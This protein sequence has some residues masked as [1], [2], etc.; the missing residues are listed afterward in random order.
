[1]KNI[2]VHCWIDTKNSMWDNA[3]LSFAYTENGRFRKARGMNLMACCSLSMLPKRM[4]QFE[5]N[6]YKIVWHNKQPY[7]LNKPI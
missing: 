1:M 4:R 3:M 2:K 6:G 5:K 7:W